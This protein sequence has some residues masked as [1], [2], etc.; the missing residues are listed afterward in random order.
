MS[1]CLKRS[2]NAFIVSYNREVEREREREGEREKKRKGGGEGGRK[3]DRLIE[4]NLH[5]CCTITVLTV[6]CACTKSSPHLLL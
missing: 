3:G 5:Y 2:N 6:H 4:V 1:L